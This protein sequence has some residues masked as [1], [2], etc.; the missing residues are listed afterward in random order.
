MAERGNRNTRSA[1]SRTS[2]FHPVTFSTSRSRSAA[3]SEAN[4][5]AC[6]GIST[7]LTGRPL[8]LPLTPKNSEAVL[9][10]DPHQAALAFLVHAQQR[11]VTPELIGG[12]QRLVA[13]A[14]GQEQRRDP[15]VDIDAGQ[16]LQRPDRL[17]VHGQGIGGAA[18]DRGVGQ[19]EQLD[20]G[21]PTRLPLTLH[22]RGP[23]GV[24]V[25]VVEQRVDEDRAAPG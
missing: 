23:G 6:G 8:I 13:G 18:G 14:R 19:P 25:A 16:A 24:Q 10:Q 2:W 15:P 1:S 5:S 11:D 4:R 7:A 9:V 17:A 3:T 21:G 22:C 12:A 20:L